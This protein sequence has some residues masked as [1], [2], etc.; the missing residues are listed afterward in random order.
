VSDAADARRAAILDAAAAVFLRYG[1]KK[2]SMDDLAR[3]A[4]LS[5]QGLYLH[6]ATKEELFKAGVVRLIEATRAAGREVLASDLPVDER[7]L[8]F[9]AAIHAPFGDVSAEH[10]SELLEATAH[11]VGDVASKL[12][13]EQ[14][15]ALTRLLKQ[16]G[17]AAAWK[18]AGLSAGEL[19]AQLFASS[20]G[21][22]LA[23]RSREDYRRR[24]RVAVALVCHGRA[25]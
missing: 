18:E 1:F 4:G 8:A 12:E 15:A 9:F 25:R 6:F 20:H 17:V 16:S 22:K 21:I 2:T 3:A 10:V 19:A 23:T 13:E 7:V 14:I 11:L 24:M 5:R